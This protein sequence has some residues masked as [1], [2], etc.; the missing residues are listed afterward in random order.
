MKSEN[1]SRHCW[2]LGRWVEGVR[3]RETQG[4]ECRGG[5]SQNVIEYLSD[6]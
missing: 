3:S 4:N 5:E 2:F 1:M 6:V